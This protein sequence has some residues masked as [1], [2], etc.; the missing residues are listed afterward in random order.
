MRGERF[1]HPRAIPGTANGH[2]GGERL[3]DLVW[4]QMRG[5]SS[6]SARRKSGAERVDR[7]IVKQITQYVVDS[8]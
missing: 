1:Q 2:A 7:L 6:Q 8:V 5:E 4:C 3:W